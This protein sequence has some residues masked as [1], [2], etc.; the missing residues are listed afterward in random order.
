MTLLPQ[1]YAI[2]IGEEWPLA[3]PFPTLA[4]VVTRLLP[5]ALV[6]GGVIFFI[7]V[8]VSGFSILAGAGSDDAAAKAR[9]HQILTY[10]V[11]GLIIMFGAYWVIQIINYI[12]GNSLKGMGL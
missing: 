12:T 2:N 7:M 8:I 4:S 6:I 11:A 10:G 9:W 1:V 5:L 3:K